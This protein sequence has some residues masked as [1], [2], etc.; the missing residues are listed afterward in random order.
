MGR[1]PARLKRRRDFLGVAATRRK[2][3]APGL[4][5]QVRPQDSGA[6]PRNS[7]GPPSAYGSPPPIRVGFT[8]SRK[9]GNA[10]TRNRVR[11]RLRAAAEA[12]LTEHAAPGHDYVVIGRGNTVRRPFA[13][14]NDDFETAL[15]RLGVWR[16]G[17]EGR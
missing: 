14:L 2:W 12:V 1:G 3:V 9:V 7:D 11:R 5:L 8:V 10:V 15:R 13:A 4:I 17:M 6:A 16:E